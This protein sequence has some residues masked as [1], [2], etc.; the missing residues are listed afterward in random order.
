MPAPREAAPSFGTHAVPWTRMLYILYS[1]DAALTLLVAATP[2]PDC[3]PCK[4]KGV[5]KNKQ[6]QRAF[7]A[8][9]KSGLKHVDQLIRGAFCVFPAAGLPTGADRGSA[10]CPGEASEPGE[11]APLSAEHR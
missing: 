8:Q 5:E 1:L 9:R 3:A 4:K 2:V 7:L 11:K 10:R 6:T